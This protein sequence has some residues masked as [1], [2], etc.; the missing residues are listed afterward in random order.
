MFRGFLIVRTKTIGE[1]F[2]MTTNVMEIMTGEDVN[3]TIGNNGERFILR[4]NREEVDV[5]ETGTDTILERTKTCVF[6]DMERRNEY[7]RQ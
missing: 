7:V 3:T 1:I 4:S 6:V 5:F 2:E